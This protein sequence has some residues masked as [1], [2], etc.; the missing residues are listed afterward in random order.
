MKRLLLFVA[1]MTS[2]T[3]SFYMLVVPDEKTQP[4]DTLSMEGD[5]GDST[6]ALQGVNIQQMSGNQVSWELQARS[7]DYNEPRH[8]ALLKNVTMTIQNKPKTTG[9]QDETPLRAE[10]REARVFG[11]TGQ[12]VL[13]G[14]V[15]L[16]QGTEIEIRGEQAEYDHAKGLVWMPGAVTIRFRDQMHDGMD[17]RFSIG[18]QRLEIRRLRV[19]R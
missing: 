15:R 3:L 1:F 11:E 16:N 14:S 19:Y 10:S 6:L 9:P 17:L 12:V 4:A 5:G 2:A 18:D 7:A 8:Q 13:T